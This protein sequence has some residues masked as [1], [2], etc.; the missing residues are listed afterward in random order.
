MVNL[1]GD[2][3]TLLF[4]SACSVFRG[5]V[6]IIVLMEVPLVVPFVVANRFFLTITLDTVN[7]S[8]E[9]VEE[10]DDEPLSLEAELRSFRW[11]SESSINSIL[12]GVGGEF[13]GVVPRL[14]GDRVMTLTGVNLGLFGSSVNS[15]IFFSAVEI[16]GSGFFLAG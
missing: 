3:L 12:C 8:S 10:D 9:D 14:W 5:L 4:V 6:R 13:G 7:P 1:T 2:N 11:Q 16:S 15:G